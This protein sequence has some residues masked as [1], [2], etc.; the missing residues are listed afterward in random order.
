MTGH[1]SPRPWEGNAQGQVRHSPSGRGHGKLRVGNPERNLGLLMACPATQKGPSWEWGGTCVKG[2]RLEL[3][4]PSLLPWEKSWGDPRA[5]RVSVARVG[6]VRACLA[7]DRAGGDSEVHDK[8]ATQREAPRG[9]WG[10]RGV[11]RHAV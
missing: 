9:A 8:A 4:S 6:V 2:W 7:P 11:G 10:E 1:Q 3:R 5:C